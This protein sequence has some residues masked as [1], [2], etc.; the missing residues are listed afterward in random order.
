MKWDMNNVLYFTDSTTVLWW[1]RT[2]KELDVFVGNRVCRILD[3]SNKSQWYHVSTEQNPADIPTRGMSGKLLA[4][5]KLWWEGPPFFESPREAWP[6]QPEVVETRDSIDGYR[7]EARRRIEGWMCLSTTRSCPQEISDKFWLDTLL[8]SPDLDKGLRACC[9]VLRFL[10]KFRRTNWSCYS[11]TKNAL[12]IAVLRAAQREGL[13]ELRH[14]VVTGT[15]VPKNIEVYSP[16][17]D[18]L[19]LIRLGGRL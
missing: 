18:K 15:K 7:K 8:R 19:G 9:Q 14:G 13:P 17:M 1:I 4:R 2:F 12:Q 10:G 5:C 6:A 3:A 11:G 16:F